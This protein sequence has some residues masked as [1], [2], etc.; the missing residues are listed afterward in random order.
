[1]I[2][3]YALIQTHEDKNRSIQKTFQVTRSL[4]EEVKV[5]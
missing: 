3:F 1:M 4:Y 2:E 5:F